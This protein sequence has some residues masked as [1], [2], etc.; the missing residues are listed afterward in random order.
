MGDYANIAGKEIKYSGLIAK[1]IVK[2]K[3]LEL[4]PMLQ[5]HLCEEEGYE[6]YTDG[7]VAL[8]EKDA[9]AVVAVMRHELLHGHAERCNSWSGD[10][11]LSNWQ[12]IARFAKDV[13]AFDA[14]C[15]WL[16]YKHMRERETEIYFS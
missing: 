12:D 10:E 8:S 3:Q 7:P 5:V 4:A 9:R 14:L 13:A 6:G 15:T 16:A 1:A 11:P 2:A